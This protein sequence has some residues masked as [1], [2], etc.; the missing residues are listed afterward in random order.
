M[1]VTNDLYKLARASATIGA[2]SRGPGP[3]AKRYVR[4]AVYR[5]EGT[6]TRAILR[7]LGL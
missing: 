1:S 6:L 7:S 4:K 3:L 5:K 2:A